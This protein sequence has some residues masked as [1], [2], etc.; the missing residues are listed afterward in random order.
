MCTLSHLFILPPVQDIL[1]EILLPFDIARLIAATRCDISLKLRKEYM[2]PVC[3]VFD[4]HEEIDLLTKAGVNI[5]LLSYKADLLHE[6]LEDAES[7]V[8]KYGN[9]FEIDLIAIAYYHPDSSANTTHF[10]SVRLTVT[11]QVLEKLGIRSDIAYSWLEHS[12]SMLS[13]TNSSLA[14]LAMAPTSNIRLK[15][16]KLNLRCCWF[17]TIDLVYLEETHGIFG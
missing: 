1:L 15:Q 2:I 14:P 9:R 5:I 8:Q 7:F 13:C 3:D 6:R 4:K 16:F 10:P 11:D 17:N 12:L